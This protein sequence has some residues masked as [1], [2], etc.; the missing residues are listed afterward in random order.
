MRVLGSSYV[1]NLIKDGARA[2]RSAVGPTLRTYHVGAGQFGFIAPTNAPIESFAAKLADSLSGIQPSSASRFAATAVIGVA[3]FTVGTA[4]PRDILRM[5]YSAAEDARK[6]GKG[7]SIYSSTQDTAHQRRF[8][9]L[10]SFGRALGSTDQLRLVYQPRIDLTSRLCVGAEALLRWRHPSLGEI[11]PAEFM[12]LVERTELAKPAT[13]WVLNAA[14]KQLA[15]WRQAGLQLQISI[16]VSATNLLEADLVDRVLGG[17]AQH[18]LA[19]DQLEIEITETGIMEDTKQ[20]LANLEALAEA[21]IR[22]AIDDFGTGYSSL[23]YLQSLPAQ[24]VK[25]D[26]S[27]V[28]GSVED[29]RQ[30]ALLSAMVSLSH[31]LGYRVVAEGVETATV[32]DLLVELGCDEAQGYLFGHPMDPDDMKVWLSGGQCRAFLR[33]ADLHGV[34]LRS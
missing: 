11:S 17:L 13:A 14:L 25:I 28:R 8:M 10:Q 5:T 27:F 7:L 2:I 24:V 22:L 34:P 30:R 23:S 33:R 31:A 16:N 4:A 32:L 19:P 20:A 1:D 18:S 6:T 21:G 26:Q 9:L 12:P 15:H 29:H 3:P